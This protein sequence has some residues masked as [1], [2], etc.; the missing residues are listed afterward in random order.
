[1]QR[2]YN[3]LSTAKTMLTD[4]LMDL[5]SLAVKI[6]IFKGAH[7]CKPSIQS[8]GKSLLTSLRAKLASTDSF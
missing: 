5:P 4:L 3:Y 6:N 7:Q 1:M 8:I 2:K